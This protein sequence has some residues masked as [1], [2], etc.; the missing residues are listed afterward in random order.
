MGKRAQSGRVY[1][2]IIAAWLPPLV[3]AGSTALLVVSA[4]AVAEALGP[5]WGA[6]VAT[7]PVSTGPAYV[8]LALQHGT[9]FLAASALSSLAANAA[10]GLFL[11]TYAASARG[12]SPWR[13][14]GAAVLVWLLASL[15]TQQVA[16]T[17]LTAVLLNLVTY[18]AGFALIGVAQ[19]MGAGP[20]PPVRRRPLD[21]PLR[22]VAVAAFVSLVVAASSALGPEATGIAAVFPIVLTSLLA[23]V[24]PR[25]GGPASALL[26]ANALR[27]MLGFGAMLLALHLLVRPWGVAAALVSALLVQV[28]WSAALLLLKRREQVRRDG[29]PPVAHA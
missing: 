1:P 24:R 16:W 6:L 4:S 13:S 12:A 9:D 28:S 26:A 18:G 17:P 29:Q 8:F 15:A 5:F 27:P 10:I 11:M 2:V 23:I 7:L 19:E 25:I 3:K 22:A 14:L 20:T 21:L